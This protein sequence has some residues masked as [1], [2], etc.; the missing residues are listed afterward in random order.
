MGLVT[1]VQTGVG[2]GGTDVGKSGTAWTVVVSQ[3]E[4]SRTGKTGS[5]W[6]RVGGM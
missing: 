2:V 6:G 3:V 1:H 4:V 5:H